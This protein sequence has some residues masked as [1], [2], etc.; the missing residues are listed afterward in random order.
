MKRKE[1]G[2]SEKVFEISRLRREFDVRY[3]RRHSITARSVILEMT[4]RLEIGR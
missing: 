4:E 3:L 1:C 2:F